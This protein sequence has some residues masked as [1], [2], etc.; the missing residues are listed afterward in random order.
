[1][2][3]V[4][5]AAENKKHKNSTLNLYILIE[6]ATAQV[7]AREAPTVTV[8]HTTL[9]AKYI[10]LCGACQLRRRE[11]GMTV[12]RQFGNKGTAHGSFAQ[13]KQ[14]RVLP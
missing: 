6:G 2:H 3:G 12:T 4:R 1:M 7:R 5:R 13:Y 11:G 10:N 14:K 8:M 9:C